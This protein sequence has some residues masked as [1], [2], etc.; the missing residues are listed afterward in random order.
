MYLNLPT[1]ILQRHWTARINAVPKIVL[2]LASATMA[3]VCATTS[4]LERPA[5]NVDAW[6]IVDSGK[7][8][9]VMTLQCKTLRS[10]RILPI[11]A[12]KSLSV[13]AKLDGHI[14]IA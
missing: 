13:L 12:K 11:G 7:M 1:T 10:T 6:M 3:L 9:S 4:T 8:E 2:D 5:N 14:L